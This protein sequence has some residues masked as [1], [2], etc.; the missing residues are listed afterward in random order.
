MSGGYFWYPGAEIWKK[1]IEGNKDVEHWW[2]EEDEIKGEWLTRQ[3]SQVDRLP[4]KFYIDVGVLEET[5]PYNGQGL[6]PNRNFKATLQAKGY[7]HY[8]VE[9]LGGHNYVCWRGSVA[10]GLIYLIGK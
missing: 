9:Y 3:F 7:P 5:D 10:D 8:Y 1:R 4:L 2:T 6:N